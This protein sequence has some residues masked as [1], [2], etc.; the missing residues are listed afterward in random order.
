MDSGSGKTGKSGK[1]HMTYQIKALEKMVK[2]VALKIRISGSGK[3]GK[4][5]ELVMC[6][7]YY[8][9]YLSLA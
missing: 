1:L 3:A 8:L 9:L 6:C 2:V 7:T 5:E 4:P